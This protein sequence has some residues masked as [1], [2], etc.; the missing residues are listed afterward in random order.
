MPELPEPPL[1]VLQDRGDLGHQ[2][3]HDVGLLAPGRPRRRAA[4]PPGRQRPGEVQ[5][6]EL[7]PRRACGAGRAR[8]RASAARSTCPTA[9]RR[10]CR[11]A[12]RRPRRRPRTA[13]R[14]CWKG[15]SMLPI[16]TQQLGPVRRDPEAAAGALARARPAARRGARARRAAAATPGA[17]CRRRP[18]SGRPSRSSTVGRVGSSSAVA[19]PAPAATRPA[20][21]RGTA[22]RG[23]G[24][25]A[26]LG[27]SA[28][29]PGRRV[30]PS[31]VGAGDVGG[32]EPGQHV[33]SVRSS[34]WPGALGR[35]R[36]RPRR[37]RRGSPPRRTCA[38]RSGRTG[39][40]PARGSC[41][42]PA[43]GWPAAGAGPATGPGGRSARTGRR[44]P[45]AGRSAR[46]TRRRPPAGWAAARGGR[47]AG[48]PA[49]SRAPRRGCPRRAGSPGAGS[50]RRRAPR[51]C[52]RP[53]PRR[54]AGW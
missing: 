5:A 49:R 48:G 33:V 6:V 23:G 19:A 53:G 7:R 51:A 30:R 11:R 29:Q 42:P 2:P 10:R 4:G 18:R 25:R 36:P 41:P 12:H 8:R 39:A 3:L 15:R 16:G 54:P 27:R 31:P 9:G 35:C 38:A 43:A 50:A 37:G 24:E 26:H 34:P 47:R 22:A 1:P 17:R 52:G 28:E 21:C 32:A 45:P 14:R 44:T 46:R 20:R 40:P 13:S